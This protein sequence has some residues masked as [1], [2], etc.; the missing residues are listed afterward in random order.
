MMA[1]SR[2]DE[3][4]E[5]VRRLEELQGE[6][7]LVENLKAEKEERLRA[8]VAR[9]EQLLDQLEKINLELTQAREEREMTIHAKSEREREAETAHEA[10]KRQAK[11]VERAHAMVRGLESAVTDLATSN[12]VQTPIPI[13]KSRR[14]SQ[15][16][17]E[18]QLSD[19]EQLCTHLQEWLNTHMAD[20]LANLHSQLE[21]QR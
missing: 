15:E 12:G 11:L 13:R 8:Q 9:N 20:C 17:A 2:D 19:I 21:G 4:G 5:L 6:V 18:R 3:R 7:R 14:E 10:L 1:E 16:G